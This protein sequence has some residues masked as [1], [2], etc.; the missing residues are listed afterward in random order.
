MQLMRMPAK[1]AINADMTLSVAVIDLAP[2]CRAPFGAMAKSERR[3][4]GGDGFEPPTLS[5]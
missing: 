2:A 4:V 5:V 1:R 3:L